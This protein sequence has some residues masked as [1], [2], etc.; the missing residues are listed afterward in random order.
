MLAANQSNEGD[1][2]SAAGTRSDAV[3]P[4]PGEAA[5]AARR[6]VIVSGSVGAGHDGVARELARRLE[7]RGYQVTIL[8]LLDGFPLAVRILLSSAY[9]MTV[10]VAPFIYE[11]TCWLAERSRVFQRL[12][13]AVCCTSC[14]WL[15]AAVSDADLV[16]AT[17]PPAGRAV[18]RL[19][20]TGKLKAPTVTY[21]TDPA[22]NYLWVHPDVDLHLTMSAATAV[23]AQERY[24]VPVISSGPLVDPAFRTTSRELARSYAREVLG[25]EPDT[26]VALVLLG[27][28]GVGNVSAALEALKKARMYPVVLCGRNRRLLRRLS[29]V[30]G[31]A[32]LGWRSDV[33]ALL[34][35]A[36]LVVHNAGGLALTESLVAGVPAIT[37]A[38]LPGHGKANARTLERSGTAP[39]ARS[40]AQLTLL[41]TEAAASQLNRWPESEETTVD[42]IC[43]L[44]NERATAAA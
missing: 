17:Y 19:K 3:L 16:V 1:Q 10:K 5:G 12:A 39:W 11:L 29:R 36:D 44:L 20:R 38:S 32:A 33:P 18:G 13:D 26:K 6:I 42:R 40:A 9:V 4:A 25:L 41:A 2:V 24:G 28:L 27:S 37:F 21:L 43:E 22:P 35:G 31:A 34:A 23:E 14:D 30:P 8:D 15:A 7:T